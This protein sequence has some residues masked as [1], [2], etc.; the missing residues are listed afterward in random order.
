MYER[1]E[2]EELLE[3]GDIIL[4][5][6]VHL[7][8]KVIRVITESHWNHAGLYAGNGMVV[9]SRKGGVQQTSLEDFVGKDI[10]VYRHKTA[11][12]STRM[13][14]AEFALSQEGD[15]YD[16]RGLFEI[17]WLLLTFRRGNARSIGT[18]NAYLCSELVASSYEAAGVPI[19]DYPSD[20]TT[21]SDI[22]LSK[23]LQRL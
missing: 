15:A 4:T 22:D 3:P 10:A 17:A 8:S 16:I 11:A 2:L 12:L 9:E 13:R 20:Q 19:S 21:P 14:V 5:H 18:S 23:R 1:K 7:L 6:G